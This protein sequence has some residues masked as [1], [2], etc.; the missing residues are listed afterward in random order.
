MAS[1]NDPPHFYVTLLS[2][3]SQKRFPSNTH[4]SFKVRLALPVGLGSTDMWEV[5]VCEVACRSYNMGSYAKVQVINADNARI[6]CFFILPQFLGS[7][8][9]G[10]LRSFIQQRHTVIMFSTM[11]ITCLWR[12]GV[13]RTYRYEY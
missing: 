7:Q 10:V 2:N 13:F 6:Y 9:V 8:Y 12:K 1:E 5:G 4:S 3:A 11:F